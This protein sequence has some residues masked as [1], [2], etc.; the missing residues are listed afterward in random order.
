MLLGTSRRGK[1]RVDEP[2]PVLD[3]P[4][5]FVTEFM[6]LG[7]GPRKTILKKMIDGTLSFKKAL[8]YARHL[9][10]MGH[11]CGWIASICEVPSFK[12][13]ILIFVL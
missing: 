7:N 3:I 9:V 4:K 5:K 6:M 2:P 8:T 11:V 12:D 10:S 13:V 1:K